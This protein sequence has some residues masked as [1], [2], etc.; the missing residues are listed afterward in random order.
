MQ[1]IRG[2]RWGVCLV[3]TLAGCSTK[4]VVNY[5]QITLLNVSGTVTLDGKPLSNAVL[6]FEN[7]DSSFSHGQTDTR[8][9]YALQ[10]DSVK[11]GCTPGKKI[12]RI[13]T[14]RKTGED[15]D[16]GDDE[17]G[18]AKVAPTVEQIPER[19]NKTSELTVEV[20]LDKTQFDFDLTSK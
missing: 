15:G 11:A 9:K 8:G 6:T 1:A 7:P 14:K 16:D 18:T 13:S 4:P 2:H 5:G 20:S 19:Y 10:F 12:V 17:E 3:L